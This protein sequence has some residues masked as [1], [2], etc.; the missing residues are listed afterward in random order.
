MSFP[1][2]SG[3]APSPIKTVG[4]MIDKG[5]PLSLQEGFQRGAG[6]AHRSIMYCH[7]EMRNYGENR[8]SPARI[9]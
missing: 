5:T 8:P 4:L 1:G 7:R 9:R 2:S 6:M 3:S